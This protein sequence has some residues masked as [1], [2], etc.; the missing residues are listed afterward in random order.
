MS[1]DDNALAAL[2]RTFG[3]IPKPERF[4]PDDGDPES[5]EHN[6][7]LCVRNRD[8]LLLSDVDNAGWDPVCSCSSAGFAYYFPTLAKFALEGPGNSYYWYADQLIYLISRKGKQN[9]FFLYCDPNQRKDVAEF[10]EYLIHTRAS[11]IVADCEPSE[12]DA[13]LSLW[14]GTASEA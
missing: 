7:L 10:L 9:R 3:S 4:F 8:T 13:C 6:A 1:N 5:E 11:Q 2:L 12:F 14:K